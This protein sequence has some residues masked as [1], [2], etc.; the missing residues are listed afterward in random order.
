MI[1]L[2]HPGADRPAA[3]HDQHIAGLNFVLLDRRNGGVLAGE[4]LGRAFVRID[5]VFIDQARIDRGAF[6][7]RSLGREVAAREHHRTRQA[8][9][10]GALRREDHVVGIDAVLFLQNFAESL[11]TLRLFPVVQFLVNRPASDAPLA[12]VDQV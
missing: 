5:A 8:T 7:D 6:D 4:Y 9:I 10:T 11:T 3:G 1:R 2:L 12:G